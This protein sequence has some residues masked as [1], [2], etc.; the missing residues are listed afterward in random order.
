MRRFTIGLV[1]VLSALLP[2]EASAQQ[3][4]STYSAGA[5]GDPFKSPQYLTLDKAGN[6][7]VSDTGNHRVQRIDRQTGVVSTIAGTGAAGY[8]GDGGP[9]RLA[10]LGCP[11]GLAFDSLGNLYIA[12]QC[13]NAVRKVAPGA[14]Q[15]MTG[16]ADETITTFAGN[17]TT[18]TTCG[19]T[20]G[21]P[22]NQTNVAGP[23]QVAIDPADNVFILATGFCGEGIRRVDAASG[24]I[25]ST[26]YLVY[27]NVN[28]SMVFDNAGSLL[29]SENAVAICS[30]VS[31]NLLTGNENCSAVVYGE[32]NPGP[33]AV[34]RAGNL[35]FIDDPCDGSGGCFAVYKATPGSD[36]TLRSGTFMLYA[37]AGRGYT[38]D[39]GP[40]LEATFNNPRGI[41]LDSANNLF[42]ADTGNNVIRRVSSGPTPPALTGVPPNP[43]NQSSATFFFSADSS[44][45]SF[46]CTLDLVS[47]SCASGV[48]YQSLVDGSH[49]FSVIG[50]SSSG[51]PSNAVSYTWTVDTTPPPVPSIDSHPSN[52]SA[53]ANASF[54]F[55]DSE[56]GVRF[57][58]GLDSLEDFCG[59]PDL[60][61]GL[62]DG[63]HVFSVKAQDAAG[64]RSAANVFAWTIQTVVPPAPHI[65]SAPAV[66][67]NKPVSTFTFSDAQTGLSFLCRLDTAAY[68]P[69][70]SPINYLGLPDGSH[71][72]SV[73]AA[74]ASSGRSSPAATYAWTLDT[75][76]PKVAISGSPGVVTIP[77]A[78][79]I[80]FSGGSSDV[81]GFLCSLDGAAFASCTPPFN[82]SVTSQGTHTLA[83]EAVDAAGNVGEA[84]STTWSVSYCHCTLF[85]DY[86]NPVLFGQTYSESS[87]D[88]Q[89][90]VSAVA[91]ASQQA[92]VS[93]IRTSDG[94]VVYS[95]VVPALY[96]A[97]WQFSP[98]STRFW[99]LT[100]PA[101]TTFGSFPVTVLDLTASTPKPILTFSLASAGSSVLQYSPSAAY[102]MAA[103]ITSTGHTAISVYRVAGVSK[104]VLVHSIELSVALFGPEGGGV[105]SWGFNQN[106][107]GEAE[108][109][110]MYAWITG[111]NL[112]SWNVVNLA[113][114]KQVI[115][116]TS[117]AI[118]AYWQFN[119][120][121][122]IIA[123]VNQS[124]LNE[125]Q[126]DLFSVDDGTHLGETGFPLDAVTLTSK[127]SDKTS[128][129][130]QEVATLTS[131]QQTIV[132]ANDPSCQPNTQPG[133]NG[134]VAPMAP[135]SNT[136]PAT[137]TF[138]VVTQAGGTGVSTS[139][140]GN[141][142]PAGF[143]LG[144][145]PVFYD[146]AT[147]A[148]YTGTIVLCFKYAG[149]TFNGQPHLFHFQNGAWVDV[150]I[151]VDA[152]NQ[153]ICGSVTSLSPFAIFAAPTNQPP[154]V[155][156]GP[157]Q[158][159]EATSPAGALVTLTGSTTD[160]DHDPLTLT[161][162][163]GASVLGIGAQ[164]NVTLALGVHTPTLTADDGHGAVSTAA[165]TITVHDTT[166]PAVKAPASLT[167]PATEAG[168]ARGNAWPA[169][170]VFLAGATATDLVDP[171]PT[172]LAPQAAGANVDNSTLFPCG[173]TQ[174]TFRYRDASGNVGSATAS[175]TVVVG[176]PKISGQIVG[177]GPLTG[178]SMFL[179]LK[180]TNTGTGNARK[181]AVDL[182]LAVSLKGPGLIKTVLPTKPVVVG[183]F[184]VGSTQTI[185][186][187]L[188]I[189]PA[190][191]QFLLTAG[192]TMFNVQGTLDLFAVTQVVN[193]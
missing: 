155:Q 191:K 165:V 12:D 64:N 177:R 24:L 103:E 140:T 44:V 19:L 16:A 56:A 29:I 22:A 142:P 146:V 106:P 137:V 164:I 31:G 182:V 97:G 55:S 128:T 38:G 7:F 108:T 80:N 70:V 78:S 53:A 156:T 71:T 122:N 51:T 34:D 123:F 148:S 124:S 131:S 47:S 69:C 25:S 73:V 76:P 77:A 151:S 40:P 189:P 35:Y 139:S 1:V 183:N 54:T 153:I 134:S 82:Q 152:L 87:P 68:S 175:V 61:T 104:G 130:F 178:G 39:G 107:Y 157:P 33:Q 74:D 166:P 36:G 111:P 184:D 190:V 126:V 3:V 90:K 27:G 85:G 141:A 93:L 192:G 171:S 52:P 26:N 86:T 62:A 162:R 186:V 154:V 173:T 58:C 10:Q 113:T 125:E 94:S 21:V 187:V 75:T 181:L 132:I 13:Q 110:F 92:N 45:A 119:P 149:I 116:Q 49:T 120:C 180:L 136:S 43:S 158:I 4:V 169:L 112:F 176:S 28:D 8:S 42:I 91:G 167:V 150:T 18:G 185:R 95:F 83:V 133:A 98:D 172:A 57:I 179:D 145:P 84:D 63:P 66:L 6:L 2:A 67:S 118:S 50:R 147:S 81:V 88:G 117:T 37:G 100:G 15:A 46:T 174:V 99:Y 20:N 30:P 163:E 89:F 41:A 188:T 193:P 121:G 105:A 129:I 143:E 161:W 144:D 60:L 114:G 14:D 168:G 72:F 135:R 59:S 17:G 96:T 109:A 101:Y 9:A 160:P 32:T 138:T 127:P 65:D 11:I 48:T 79:Q 5:L 23:F 115:S 102:L 159:V 170:A